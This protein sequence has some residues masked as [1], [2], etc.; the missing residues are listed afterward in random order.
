MPLIQE[1]HDSLPYIDRDI[2]PQERAL[3][4]SQIASELPSDSTTSL[5]PAIPEFPA[6]KLST[7]IE[8]ELARKSANQPL[9]G[10]IDTTRYEAL[11]PPSTDPTSDQDRPQVLEDWKETLRK[12]YTSSQHLQTRLTNLALL[13]EFGK[14]AWLIGNAQLEDILRGLEKDLVAV[15]AQTDE[16]NKARKGEELAV[17][18]KIEGLDQTWQRGI[19]RVIE[20]EL[21]AEALRREI[22]DR[23]R[24]GAL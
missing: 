15:R 16:V 1:S 6:P 22:L 13:D 2:T 10:G 20:V 21:A 3:V 24:Q 17:K 23:R 5:H 12:A 7:L 11:D 19:G 9:T 14:N 4:E 8:H 18:G